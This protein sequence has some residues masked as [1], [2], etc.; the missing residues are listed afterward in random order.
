MPHVKDKIVKL[1]ICT[2][3]Y[4]QSSPYK[5]TLFDLPRNRKYLI[6]SIVG[7]LNL[8]HCLPVANVRHEVGMLMT[9]TLREQIVS[10]LTMF[11]G[12]LG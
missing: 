12:N 11:Q 8:L 1:L 9:H 6:E 3:K 4:F 5:R 7:L 2:T 10:L